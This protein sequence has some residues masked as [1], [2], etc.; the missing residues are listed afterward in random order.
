[1]DTVDV[2]I[3]IYIQ[4]VEPKTGWNISTIDFPVRRIILWKSKYY[5]EATEIYIQFRSVIPSNMNEETLSSMIYLGEYK[6]VFLCQKDMIRFDYNNIPYVL[7]ETSNIVYLVPNRCSI[8]F[9]QHVSPATRKNI[10]RDM[11]TYYFGGTYSPNYHSEFHTNELWMT[12]HRSFLCK[13]HRKLRKEKSDYIVMSDIDANVE[14]GYDYEN[15]NQN[16]S[17]Q[18]PTMEEVEEIVETE[19][20]N[21]YITMMVE[22]TEQLLGIAQPT[23]QVV[24]KRIDENDIFETPEYIIKEKTVIPWEDTKDS[25]DVLL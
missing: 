4:S 5:Y 20:K 9:N 6:P 7:N 16:L 14:R 18:L 1:M 13:R 24:S 11:P 17:L 25:Y 3:G 2:P 15:D 22:D 12:F 21:E 10:L 19:K 8:Q 23:E